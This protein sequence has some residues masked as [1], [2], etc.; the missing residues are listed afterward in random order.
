M[1]Q[2]ERQSSRILQWLLCWAF[3][4]TES[5]HVPAYEM[6]VLNFPVPYRNC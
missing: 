4:L 6:T 3:Q 5:G 1:L 2:W